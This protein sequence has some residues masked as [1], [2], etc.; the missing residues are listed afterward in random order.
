MYNVSPIGVMLHKNVYTIY[1]MYRIT[2]KVYSLESQPYRIVFQH[3]YP[4][5]E[6]MPSVPCGVMSWYI[7]RYSSTKWSS[8]NECNIV[9]S[10][11]FVHCHRCN[12]NMVLLETVMATLS[13]GWKDTTLEVRA[14][15]LS[16]M[17][18]IRYLKED[19]RQHYMTPVVMALYNGLDDYQGRYV[20][21]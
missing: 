7:P 3:I 17:S 6:P 9:L 19:Q 13:T 11:C 15:S 18:N 10:L 2:L 14:V 1:I 4:L 20:L 16:G 5:V 21:S 8:R 12:D